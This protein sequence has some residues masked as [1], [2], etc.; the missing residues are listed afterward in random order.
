MFDLHPQLANDTTKVLD[1]EICRVL[2]LKDSRYPWIILVPRH[3]NLV[4]LHDLETSSYRIVTEEIRRASLI[5]S[6]LFSAHK[7]NVGALGNMVPQLH[8]HVIVRQPDDPAWPA[9]VWGVGPAIPYAASDLADRVQLI[10][11]AF[12][13]YK[14][15]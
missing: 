3:E 11:S 1:L 13:D 5:M 10:K 12:A 6:E 9:P 14:T 8:I 15:S 7:I 2:L 4:E